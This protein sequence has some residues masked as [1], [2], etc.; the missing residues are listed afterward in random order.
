MG[1]LKLS[2]VHVKENTGRNPVA[3]AVARAK[4]KKAVVDQKIAVLMLDQ[5]EACDELLTG[6]S[7][8]M[9]LVLKACEL[10][11]LKSPLTSLLRASFNACHQVRQANRFDRIQAVAICAGLDHA[12]EL[13]G[14]VKPASI[15]RAW[16]HIVR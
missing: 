1:Q 15:N 4:L 3:Q 5:G 16:A 6:V 13:A 10:E 14:K 2:R 9:E 8:T 7:A 11:G 12:T